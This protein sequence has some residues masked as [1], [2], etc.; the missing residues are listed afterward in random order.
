MIRIT[1][2]TPSLVVQAR[3]RCRARLMAEGIDVLP[4]QT[5]FLFVRADESDA[6]PVQQALRA[7]GILVRH[8]S[9]PLLKPWL[10]VTIGTTE[11]METV[12]E[13]LIRCIK[14]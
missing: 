8:F 3:D 1:Q 10:R 5:N 14:K 4:S 12:T 13:A 11:D 2:R 7:E 9:V 6:A